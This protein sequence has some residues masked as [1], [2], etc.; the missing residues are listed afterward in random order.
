MFAK[1]RLRAKQEV[2][3]ALLAQQRRLQ[4]V[5]ERRAAEVPEHGGNGVGR[6]QRLRA[7]AAQGT[8]PGHAARVAASGQG[9]P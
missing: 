3:D 6:R 7:M 8:G 5:A 4:G 2:V 9:Q 1:A